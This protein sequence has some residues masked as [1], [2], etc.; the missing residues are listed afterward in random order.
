[1]NE[2]EDLPYFPSFLRDFQTEFIGFVVRRFHVYRSFIN[3]LRSLSMPK[4]TM[5][6]LCSGS[7]EAAIYVFK[8]SNCFSDLILSDK[9]PNRSP[10]ENK[11]PYLSGSRDVLEMEF[12]PGVCYTMFNAF[13][14]FKDEDKL[15]IAKKIIASGSKS[16]FVEILEP[17]IICSLK[18][19]FIS[20][21]GNLLLA[22]FVRPFSLARIFFT[23]IIPIN[24]LTITYDGLVSVFRS[25]TLSNYRK[26]FVDCGDSLR[27]LKL[28]KDLAALTII[29]ID[30]I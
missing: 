6:D 8:N 29:Q 11:F 25:G 16:F 27:V 18:V 15:K 2:L 30:P 10:G 14:H 21:I 1:M 4:Q 13:H 9:F 20:T 19:L 17:N 23:Y 3:Y 28:K 5:V 24:I 12:H 26:L 7:G 22:P